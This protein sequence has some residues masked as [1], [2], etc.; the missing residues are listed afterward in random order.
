MVAYIF[1]SN[2]HDILF[3]IHFFLGVGWAGGVKY[4][5]KGN[6]GLVGTIHMVIFI[7]NCSMP[8]GMFWGFKV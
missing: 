8:L 2:D 4:I 5:F 3:I 6:G 7:W 1:T